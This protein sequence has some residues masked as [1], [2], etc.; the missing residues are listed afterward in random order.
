[1]PNTRNSRRQQGP[2]GGLIV[3]VT[4]LEEE[5]L[6]D[7]LWEENV[8]RALSRTLAAQEPEFLAVVND[9]Q[10]IIQ[11]PL[12]TAM[13]PMAVK[14]EGV[15][16]WLGQDVLITTEVIT[17]ER[18]QREKD[19]APVPRG[20]RPVTKNKERS[21]SPP[22]RKSST[23]SQG[24]TGGGKKNPKL[25][26][27]S[28]EVE[29]GKE[30]VGY[31]QWKYS[32][33]QLLKNHNEDDV[34]EAIIGSLRKSAFDLVRYMDENATVHEVLEKLDT[35]YGI[36][37]DYDSMMSNV[38]NSRQSSSDTVVGFATH[39]E[40]L[41]ND[42]RVHYPL[43]LTP[44]SMREHL[45]DRL[46]K[47][48]KGNMRQKLQHWYDDVDVTYEELL[49]NAIK[50]EG[51]LS[52]ARDGV[53][54][55]ARMVRPAE[56]DEEEKDP[57]EKEKS[58]EVRQTEVKSVSEPK[59]DKLDKLAKEMESLKTLVAAATARPQYQPRGGGFQRT[60]RAPTAEDQCHRCKG[61]G[62]F[63]YQCATH[64]NAKVEGDSGTPPPPQKQD[65]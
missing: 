14:F 54:A 50:A 45:R 42:V 64:L 19:K 43:R 17:P 15:D 1:M 25:G 55:R 9:H 61:Y 37:M 65:Q 62:H 33:R 58:K 35:F 27:F 41:L 39:L 30:Y 23:T 57:E 29:K 63:A 36:T 49:K 20:N 48:L 11:P 51:E 16:S 2:V 53:S 59:E 40:G 32:V 56:D 8:V 60:R 44:E 4:D 21:K 5:S 34:K 12:G 26:W 22:S 38:F 18:L 28:G 7:Y 47:G 6:P 52:S 31:P 10:F 3:S 13:E 24:S 46:F